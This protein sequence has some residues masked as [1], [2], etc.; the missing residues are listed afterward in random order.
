MLH[1]CQSKFGGKFMQITDMNWL[2]FKT[3]LENESFDIC[4]KNWKSSEFSKKLNLVSSDPDYEN[5]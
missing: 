5:N 3:E 1:V 4:G 2:P